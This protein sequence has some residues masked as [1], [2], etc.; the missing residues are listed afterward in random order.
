MT[1][2]YRAAAVSAVLVKEM[3]TLLGA[4]SH[5][6]ATRCVELMDRL[7]EHDEPAFNEC[8]RQ[9][10]DLKLKAMATFVAEI[11][12]RADR[13]LPA[14]LPRSVEPEPPPKPTPRVETRRATSTLADHAE[15]YATEDRG[16]RFAHIN[17]F[18]SQGEVVRYPRL[19]E[20]SPHAR[21]PVPPE[22]PLGYA[23]DA[24]PGQEVK[25]SEPGPT[26]DEL[27][28]EI[29]RLKAALE[30]TQSGDAAAPE[31][32]AVERCLPDGESRPL[33]SG[34]PHNSSPTT[35]KEE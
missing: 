25:V 2:Y 20:N 14:S 28:K 35:L 27:L 24:M 12:K 6:N 30:A 13:Q 8:L 4:P 11:P 33:A 22:P 34:S 29:A 17:E 31:S 21:D 19:P 23:I 15:F 26:N 5:D 16:G 9:E 32:P 10:D 7:R 3:R 18:I 1:D